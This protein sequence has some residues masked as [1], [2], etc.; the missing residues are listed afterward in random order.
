MLFV[1]FAQQCLLFVCLQVI[2]VMSWQ[3]LSKSISKI[4]H[5]SP[6]SILRFLHTIIYTFIVSIFMI[7]I[8]LKSIISGWNQILLLFDCNI[9]N[10]SS[11]NYYKYPLIVNNKSFQLLPYDII[12]CLIFV[13]IFYYIFDF[14][15]EY[16]YVSKKW[17]NITNCY[18]LQLLMIYTWVITLNLIV[19]LIRYKYLNLVLILIGF[20]EITNL[21]LSFAIITTQ[22]LQNTKYLIFSCWISLILSILTKIIIPILLVSFCLY[23]RLIY[24]MMNDFK[25]QPKNSLDNFLDLLH[26]VSFLGVLIANIWWT[27]N[28][29]ESMEKMPQTFHHHQHDNNKKSE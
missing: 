19:L 4:I 6:K 9:V 5:I 3:S 23:F 17:E 24:W 29:N 7:I 16:F 27:I 10:F 28:L 21:I 11:S 2:L 20:T 13:A 14:L 18:R 1:S 15:I 8:L 22:Y 25:Y 12:Y 26:F